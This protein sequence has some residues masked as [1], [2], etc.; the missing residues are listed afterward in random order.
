MFIGAVARYSRQAG[1]GLRTV[2]PVAAEEVLL[3]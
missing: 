1:L 3:N 2:I